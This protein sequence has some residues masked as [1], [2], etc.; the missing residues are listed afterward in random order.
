MP[1]NRSQPPDPVIP[2]MRTIAQ[3]R[4]TS[5][6]RTY[7]RAEFLAHRSPAARHD[8]QHTMGSDTGLPELLGCVGMGGM[9]W[10]GQGDGS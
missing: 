7:N 5:T 10:R 8:P 6:T 2:P 1:T 4:G 3:P 9:M